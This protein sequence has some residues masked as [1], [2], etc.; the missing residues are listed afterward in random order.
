MKETILITRIPGLAR[1]AVNSPL[2]APAGQPG[3][4]G[5]LLAESPEESVQRTKWSGEQG[6]SLFSHRAEVD[7]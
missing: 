7:V 1:F 3:A 5:P 6:F 2:T 4:K